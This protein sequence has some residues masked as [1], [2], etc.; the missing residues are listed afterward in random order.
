MHAAREECSTP[1][2]PKTHGQGWVAAAD[3]LTGAHTMKATAPPASTRLAD[4]LVRGDA[5]EA[6]STDLSVKVAEVG[7]SI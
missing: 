5:T 4:L 3:V 1:H 2:H 6:C 7:A